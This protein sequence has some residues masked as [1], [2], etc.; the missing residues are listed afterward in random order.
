MS[1]RKTGTIL[2]LTA[3]LLS[4]LSGCGSNSYKAASS[5][6][7]NYEYADAV[8]ETMAASRDFEVGVAEEDSDSGAENTADT[9]PENQKWVITMN[10]DTETEDMDAALSS[11]NQ[12]IRELNGYIQEQNIRNGSSYS[13]SRYRSASLTV[14]IPAEQLDSFTASLTEF[15]NVVSSSRSAE[16]ITL[17]YVDTETRITALET[18]RER[19]LELMEQA[20]TMSDLLEIESRLTDVN[21]ELERYGS[22]L[23]TMDNQVS[24]ATIYLSVREVKE[25]T[26]VAEQTLWEKI[27]SGFLDSL[28]GLGTGIVNF[29]A[30]IVIKLPYLVVYGLILW[31]LGILIR[32]WRRRRAARKA[33]KKANNTPT[34]APDDSDKE[35]NS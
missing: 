18:E 11:L 35:N 9:L 33:V 8:A 12:Q 34:K 31:G 23:R 14:R 21:Y 25:Y 10:I 28:K 15:T 30:W 26:P 17:S 20:E 5:A 3:L 13:S 2:L 1:I 4:I 29:F 27:S 19:L 6:M 16:D 24:Y 32:R 22:R 7:G